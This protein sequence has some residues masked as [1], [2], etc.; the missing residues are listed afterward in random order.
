MNRYCELNIRLKEVLKEKN[1]IFNAL[2]KN[3]TSFKVGGPVDILVTPESYEEVRSVIHICKDENVP[4]YIVGK[5]S[6]ILVKDGGIR[7]LVIKLC[8][9]N[10]IHIKGNK[11][12]SQCGVNIGDVSEK[13]CELSLK[14]I[15]FACGIPGTVGGAIAMN[16]GA[17]NGEISE[18]VESAIVIDND[19]N[20]KELLK[21]DMEFGYRKSAILNHNYIALEVTFK[22][23]NGEFE[24]IKARIEDLMKRRTERQPLEY[25]SAGSTFKRPEGHF[26]SK[27]IQDSDLKGVHVGDA[28]VSVKHSGFI[29]NK[30]SASAKDVLEL[31]KIVQRTVKEKYQVELD[32]EVRIIGED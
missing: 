1:I 23:E 7:G 9:L 13:A 30:G 11:I 4:Y 16:A 10:K 26:A 2:M 5:G 3:H 12:I 31:I 6:N 8:K 17:Y 29:I 15:E 19:G 25:P 18:V 22:L 20:L 32:T 28:E 21:T 24:K 14:G 27:L